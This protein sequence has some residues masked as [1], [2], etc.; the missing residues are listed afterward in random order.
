MEEDRK[1][2]SR[3]A[4]QFGSA[5]EGEATASVNGLLKQDEIDRQFTKE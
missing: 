2:D 5:F 4:A 3:L 1:V